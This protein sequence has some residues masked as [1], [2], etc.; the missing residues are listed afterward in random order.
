MMSIGEK[1]SKQVFDNE[2]Q[3]QF[4]RSGG[5][6]GQNVNKVN[7]KVILKF[8]IPNSQLLEDVEKEILLRKL[9]NKIDSEGNLLIQTQEKRSQL[10]NK[11][12]A[13][14]RFYD[15]LKTAF[16]KKKRRVA[17]R[18]GKAAI[19]KRLKQKRAKAQKK[20]NRRGGEF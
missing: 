20:E 6:G 19:E 15:I 12:L 9:E 17:T 10:Q 7:S 16:H 13:V 2:L 11:V 1:I 4:A 5:P 14:T 3:F 18:P 8:D